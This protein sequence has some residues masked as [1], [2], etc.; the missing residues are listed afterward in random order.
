MLQMRLRNKIILTV[1]L[2]L[3]ALI[4][5][6]YGTSRIVVLGAFE[7]LEQDMA[8]A[9]LMRVKEAVLAE[10]SDLESTA[11]DWAS[12]D[13][14]YYPMLSGE[15]G[16]VE[17]YL[18]STSFINCRLNLIAFI[19][20][21]GTIRAAREYD[22]ENNRSMPLSGELRDVLP[23]Y[24][25][26]QP[27]DQSVGLMGLVPVNDKV[28]ILVSHPILTTAGTGP[29]TGMLVMGRAVDKSMIERFARKTCLAL[30][31]YSVHDSD[32]PSGITEALNRLKSGDTAWICPQPDGKLASY[33][34]MKDVAG[35]PLLV[36]RVLTSREI[37]KHG[38][39][40][41]RYFMG[42]LLL[43]GLIFTGAVAILLEKGIIRRIQRISASVANLKGSYDF[44][45][46]L[47]DHGGGRTLRSVRDH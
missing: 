38:E 19:D 39:G 13:D 17:K 37:Y 3:M 12:W 7:Q 47:P 15:Y 26:L 4:L 33:S 34:W 46:R 40:T 35:N 44:S 29:A 42:W 28:M 21:S 1:S 23:E 2:V 5:I 22:L 27:P 25:F 30:S 10:Q 31:L 41:L 36:I 9:N 20:V 45:A 14:I 32:L 24:G 43:I 8:Q 6:V 18:V 16:A 11:K